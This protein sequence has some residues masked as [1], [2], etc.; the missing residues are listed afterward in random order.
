MIL[1]WAIYLFWDYRTG[2]KVTTY[3]A[4]IQCGTK[5]YSCHE[6]I[7]YKDRDLSLSKFDNHM[8]ICKN[9]AR[10][11]IISNVTNNFIKFNGKGIDKGSLR[12]KY[13]KFILDIRLDFGLLLFLVFSSR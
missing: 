3:I 5:C 12:Y 9:C 7:E 8:S 4:N 11:E 10:D 2:K 13:L 1:I 6:D